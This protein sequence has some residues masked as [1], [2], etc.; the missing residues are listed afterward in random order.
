MNRNVVVIPAKRHSERV[1]DKNWRDFHDGKSLVDLRIEAARAANADEIVVTTDR[2]MVPELRLGPD[3]V[4]HAREPALCG[5]V[6]CLHDLFENVL[7]EY[8]DD[9]VFWAHPTSPFVRPPTIRRA[10][11][12]ARS[13]VGSCVLGVER[14]QGFFWARNRPVNYDPYNQPRSQDLEPVFRVTGGVHCSL[15]RNFIE[16]G[17][18]SFEPVHM[19]ELVFPE[20][21]DIDEIADWELAKVIAK[22]ENA[23]DLPRSHG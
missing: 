9:L 8:K 17:A 10:F 18:V 3:V 16:K 4:I 23:E 12:T 1:L 21:I 19:M 6:V 13:C 11:E 20:T 14:L 2:D 22:G 7:N 15:G 5:N